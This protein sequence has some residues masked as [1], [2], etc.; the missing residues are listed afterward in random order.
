MIENTEKVSTRRKN[1][2]VSYRESDEE[3]ED[4][5]DSYVSHE[6]IER[7]RLTR[8]R[9]HDSESSEDDDYN[10]DEDESYN[11]DEEDERGE[12]DEEEK[13]LKEDEVSREVE[14]LKTDKTPG[15][16]KKARGGKGARAKKTEKVTKEKKSKQEKKSK[17]PKPKKPAKEKVEKPPKKPKLLLDPDYKLEEAYFYQNLTNENWDEI[18]NYLNEYFTSCKNSTQELKSF[19]DNYPKLK[20]G[21]HNVA[22]LKKM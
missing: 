4:L 6:D 17:E 19:F 1:K 12:D 3:D 9:N 21:D 20:K 15:K 16:N 13:D 18:K 14:D 2:K 5:E 8:K 7:K 11:E 22:Q 10:L